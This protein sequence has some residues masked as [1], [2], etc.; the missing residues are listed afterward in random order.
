MAGVD[1]IEAQPATE[2]RW[3][4]V[5]S[6]VGHLGL[7]VIGAV[8]LSLI[9]DGGWLGFGSAAF[10][11]LLYAVMWRFLLAPGSTRR[12]GVRERWTITLVA[13]PMVIVLATLANVWIP[14]VV[15]GSFVLL[16]DALN[17]RR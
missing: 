3:F 9:S 6:L 4:A 17:Q 16:G 13:V 15:A 8:S 7:L 12:L 10:F 5:V 2:I 11:I 14:A 1:E